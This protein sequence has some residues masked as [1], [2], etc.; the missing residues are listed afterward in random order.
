MTIKTHLLTSS[1]ADI[2]HAAALLRE[3]GLVAF[4]T[5]TVYGLG[6]NAFDQNAVLRI[7]EAKGRPSFNPLIVHVAHASASEEFAVW[8][9]KARALAAAF[10]PGPLTLVL[11]L[12]PDA[13][14]APAVSAGNTTVAIRV[15]A[16]PS[17]QELLRAAG[18]PIA[19]P[20]ANRSGQISPTTADHVQGELLGRIE[21]IVDDGPCAVGIESTIFDPRTN[22]I[23]RPG[24]ITA[25]D[26]ARMTGS[27]V[28]AALGSNDIAPT[29]PGQL[30]SHYA[31]NSALRLG[32]T[33]PNATEIFIGFGDIKGDFT[34]SAA[35]SLDEAANQLYA[36]LR[37]ADSL[38]EREGK[39]LAMAPLPEEGIGL[40]L[41]D[42][43]TRAA[44]PRGKTP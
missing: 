37:A 8:D 22:T 15:P 20:S 24:S 30:T 17:A 14:I 29:A 27:P 7:Y 28:H 39:T 25:E 9:D 21:A 32:A 31:P 36:I 2:E 41:K 44:A 19:A 11:P 12:K 42:R 18:C 23:L 43:L 38:A 33:Q 10:W 13:P 26:L 16:T 40:A 4:R 6:A 5:E 35:G 1:R 34:L 3:G